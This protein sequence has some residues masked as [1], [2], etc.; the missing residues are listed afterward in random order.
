[1]KLRIR[2]S[3]LTASMLQ[4]FPLLLCEQ[5][6]HFARGLY[7]NFPWKMPRKFRKVL[8]TALRYAAK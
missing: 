3:Q 1:M 4:G 7:A 2:G 6:V 5:T 8:R